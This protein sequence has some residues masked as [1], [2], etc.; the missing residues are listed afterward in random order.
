MK[1]IQMKL[2]KTINNVNNLTN[3]KTLKT[4]CFMQTGVVS[5]TGPSSAI[6]GC[7]YMQRMQGT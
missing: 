7:K 1:K 4:L 3:K 6:G 2:I 5:V